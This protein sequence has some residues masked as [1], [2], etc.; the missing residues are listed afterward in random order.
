MD[1]ARN[2]GGG[3]RCLLSVATV[4]RKLDDERSYIQLSLHRFWL[5]GHSTPVKLCI[6][7]NEL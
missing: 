2:C 3:A 1:V 4:L 6:G 7:F 5:T